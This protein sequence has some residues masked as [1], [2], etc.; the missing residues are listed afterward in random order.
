MADAF[1]RILCPIYLDE[2]SP[3]VLAHARHFARFGDGTVHLLHV[4][5]T[6]ELHLLSKIYRPDESGGANISNAAEIAR[7]ELSAAAE[8][9]AETRFEVMTA[10]DSNPAAGILE[11]AKEMHADLVVM[12]SHGRTGLAHLIVG[13]VAEKVVRESACPVLTIRQGADSEVSAFRKIL[14]PVDIAERSAPALSVARQIAERTGG[15]VYPL[16]VVPTEDVYL[17]RDVYHAKD[18]EGTN[19]VQAEKVAKARLDEVARTHLGGVACEPVVHVS[20]DPA[21]T[22]LEMEKD[23]GADLLVMATHGFTGLFHLLLGSLTEKMMREAGC[24]VLA[25]HQ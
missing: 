14:V 18:G 15:T 24:P 6:D 3:R 9:L 12:A 21:R 11:A 2:S 10:F 16:H 13:S 4:V 17:Q 25:I 19:L 22:F 5:P 23:V 20:N 7:Q 8:H 1:R